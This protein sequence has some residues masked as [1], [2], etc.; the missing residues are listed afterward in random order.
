MLFGVKMLLFL[1]LTAAQF[2]NCFI[3][4]LDGIVPSKISLTSFRTGAVLPD[5]RPHHSA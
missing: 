2:S 3:L 5:L 4:Y 1:F